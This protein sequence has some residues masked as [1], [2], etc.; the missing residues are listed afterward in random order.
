MTKIRL[1]Y[2]ERR[3]EMVDVEF[4]YYRFEESEF[5]EGLGQTTTYSRIEEKRIIVVTI[6]KRYSRDPEY[7]VA[8]GPNRTPSGLYSLDYLLGRGE[9]SCSPEAFEQALNEA[10]ADI[11]MAVSNPKE[12]K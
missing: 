10:L 2:N 9:Y 6:D 12:D 3:D 4:P 5:D 11:A 8:M 7:R 1:R